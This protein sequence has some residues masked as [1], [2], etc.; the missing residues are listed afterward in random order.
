MFCLC[1]H[2]VV[3][4]TL[5]LSVLPVPLA[6]M[7]HAQARECHCRGEIAPA[8]YPRGPG[9]GVAGAVG[10]T[11]AT[12]SDRCVLPACGAG[13]SGFCEAS[14]TSRRQPTASD[15]GR[16]RVSPPPCEPERTVRPHTIMRQHAK[17]EQRC[18]MRAAPSCASCALL[19]EH[20][21]TWK[22]YL[23][24]TACR[25]FCCLAGEGR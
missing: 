6:S 4:L 24:W 2:T 9:T 19:R 11:V 13:L 20:A 22:V 14:W 10:S 21:R 15:E 5:S 3:V 17:T 12:A 18:L 8:R 1:L 16:A 7:S 25:R 23:T